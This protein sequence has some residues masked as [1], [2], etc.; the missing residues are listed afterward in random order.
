VLARR[1]RSIRPAATKSGIG[2]R[3]GTDETG[4]RTHGP[5][6][7]AQSGR[8]PKSYFLCGSITL[9]TGLVQQTVQIVASTI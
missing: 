8:F 6:V 3:N 2:C 5:G 7:K 1:R 4:D 9:S